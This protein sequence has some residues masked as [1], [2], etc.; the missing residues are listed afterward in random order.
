MLTYSSSSCY[1]LYKTTTPKKISRNEELRSASTTSEVPS[2]SRTTPQLA[3]AEE[4]EH[5]S[6]SDSSNEWESPKV[7]ITLSK[8][9]ENLNSTH[10]SLAERS[11]IQ[12]LPW[13]DED[14][15]HFKRVEIS[16]FASQILSN[17]SNLD[18]LSLVFTRVRHQILLKA[19][20]NS[21]L[22]ESVKVQ[23]HLSPLLSSLES[24]SKILFQISRHTSFA[25]LSSDPGRDWESR[26][27][28]R[29][30]MDSSTLVGKSKQLFREAM[31]MHHELKS[32]GYLNSFLERLA[33]RSAMIIHFNA[34]SESLKARLDVLF[35]MD[36]GWRH[37][38]QLTRTQI[39]KPQRIQEDEPETGGEVATCLEV[40]PRYIIVAL[41]YAT[42]S[43]I[44]RDGSFLRDLVG[45][46]MGVWA[47]AT[48]GDI[49]V[50]GGVDRDLRVWNMSSGFVWPKESCFIV[51][52]ITL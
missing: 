48:H 29:A 34:N 23:E 50:S 8:T 38:G 43:I 51:L 20:P 15:T 40:T 3:D 9:D 7:E 49:L 14:L 30:W 16:E 11:D 26:I 31:T 46:I 22:M 33:I 21:R 17:L 1:L 10:N 39:T 44:N 4:L 5:K 37:G 41:D 12:D 36:D 18:R 47:V 13:Y 35:E 32:Q 19:E 25:L 45:H 2:E 24:C 6:T 27:W 42:I 28:S 52:T